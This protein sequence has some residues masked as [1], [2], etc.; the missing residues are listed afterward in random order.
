M[1]MS[2]RSNFERS[3]KVEVD[4]ENQFSRCIENFLGERF[5]SELVSVQFYCYFRNYARENVLKGVELI[6][7]NNFITGSFVIFLDL[8]GFLTMSQTTI[9]SWTFLT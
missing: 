8:L 9:C 3:Y 5:H 6:F 7:Q 4:F 2:L 1:F